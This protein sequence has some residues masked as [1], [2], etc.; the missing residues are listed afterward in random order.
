M[1]NLK[2]LKNILK[3]DL[4]HGIYNNQ[5]KYLTFIMFILL[6]SISNGNAIKNEGGNIVDLFFVNYKDMGYAMGIGEMNRLPIIWI[7]INVFVAFI[8]GDFIKTDLKNNA[9]YVLT[10][11]KSF[12]EY[13]ISKVLWVFI[14]V[15]FLYVGLFIITYFTGCLFINN[16]IEWS[17]LSNILIKNMLVQD[18]TA[19]EFM[20]SLFLLYFTTSFTISLL[21]INL[22]LFI[23]S[24]YS[25][26]IIILTACLSIFIDNQMFPAIHSM[27][28]K[29]NYFDSIHELTI[30][31]S[32][33]YNIVFSSIAIY[34]GYKIIT[35]KDII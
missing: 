33:I 5:Y 20:V 8:I 11:T 25:F 13:W 30:L 28:L 9:V 21:Q 34:S 32:I 4:L 14:N 18:I 23:K 16:S 26:L 1:I 35:K 17:S 15:L 6:L 10:R 3:R 2:V 19:K 7:L 12:K 24:R 31:K 29:H 27:I 22:T